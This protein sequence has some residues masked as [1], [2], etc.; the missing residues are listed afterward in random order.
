MIKHER[1]NARDSNISDTLEKTGGFRENN[2][3]VHASILHN[4]E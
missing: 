4:R 2:V 1:E 3:D